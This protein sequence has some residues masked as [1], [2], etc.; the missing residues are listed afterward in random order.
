L[1]SLKSQLQAHCV[2]RCGLWVF[3]KTYAEKEF[4]LTFSVLPLEEIS[5][6]AVD[7]VKTQSLKVGTI[8]HF[9]G[10]V[11]DGHKTNICFIK[12]NQIVTPEFYHPSLYP[13]NVNPCVTRDSLQKLFPEFKEQEVEVKSIAQV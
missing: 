5:D 4:Q 6:I 3:H 13:Y 1:K 9:E 11:L 2:V 12:Q 10:L 7:L 8:R